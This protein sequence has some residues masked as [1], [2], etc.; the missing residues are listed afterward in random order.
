MDPGAPVPFLERDA[1][2]LWLAYG[3]QR[4][5]HFA[6]IRFKEVHTFS[7]GDPGV[8]SLAEHPL[9]SA[10]LEFYRFYQV[11]DPELARLGLKRWLATF[12]DDM[13]DVIAREAEIV[14]R[15]IQAVGPSHAIAVLRT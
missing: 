10:G 6:V 15:A 4:F 5:A 3:T 1:A 9:Y 11:H 7:L 13:L 14:V 2:A 8:E 12:P